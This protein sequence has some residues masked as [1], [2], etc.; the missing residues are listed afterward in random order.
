MAGRRRR[1]HGPGLAV[2]VR[3]LCGPARSGR[4]GRAVAGYRPGGA[5]YPAG[6]VRGREHNLPGAPGN[7]TEDSDCSF[8][9]AALIRFPDSAAPS[10]SA[11]V[12]CCVLWRM[13]WTRPGPPL[14][15]RAPSLQILDVQQWERKGSAMRAYCE[16]M[17]SDACRFWPPFTAHAGNSPTE[18]Q[19]YVFEAPSMIRR[20]GRART[21]RHA[22]SYPTPQSAGRAGCLQT[23]LMLL[24]RVRLK[25]AGAAAAA[26][27]L[28]QVISRSCPPHTRLPPGAYHSL[29]S[30]IPATQVGVLV[31]LRLPL[32]FSQLWSVLPGRA[33]RPGARGRVQNPHRRTIRGAHKSRSRFDPSPERCSGGRE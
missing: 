9:C 28:S 19:R 13:S 29:K 6:G 22:A 2:L 20:N 12:N 27:C 33:V 31:L 1:R 14:R 17:R 10:L 24:A 26:A 25:A 7:K 8:T 30:L 11:A 16:F 21:R 18:Q 32:D 4:V 3:Q 23:P 5:G 15:D